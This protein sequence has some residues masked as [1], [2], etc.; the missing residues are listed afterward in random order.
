M[1]NLL[2]SI[3]TLFEDDDMIVVN[4]PPLLLTIPDRFD[5]NLPNLHHWLR[6]KHEDM[7]IV[8]RLDKETSGVICFAKN[9]A[10]H[11]NLSLQFNK[12]TIQKEYQTI[13]SG[14]VLK[15]KGTIDFPIGQASRQGRM[16]VDSHHGKH[17]ITH[18]EVIERFK[19]Y[20][21]LSVKI[22]TGRTHQIRVHMQAIGYPLAVDN[23]Y[24]KDKAFYLS[25]VKRKYN[26]PKFEEE[27]PI[28]RRLTLHAF[29]LQ[30]K[31]PT[32]NE[33]LTFTAPLPKDFTVML[34]QLRKYNN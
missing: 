32:T 31:H 9:K 1:A 28:M 7:L 6:K 23:L 19:Q 17:A 13:V 21:L 30:L 18:Y 3:S 33:T 26:L 20:S 16:R 22:E 29:K 11:R 8:H 5:A 14:Y 27:R 25:S 10:A 4:K 34:K 24:G 15:D 12:R 2:R